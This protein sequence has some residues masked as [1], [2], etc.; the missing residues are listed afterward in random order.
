MNGRLTKSFRRL[1]QLEASV[2]LGI[3]FVKQLGPDD[4]LLVHQE[5]ARVGYAFS[6][7]LGFAIP[8]SVG[9]NGV[10]AFI[11]QQRECNVVF[12]LRSLKHRERVVA[13]TDDLEAGGFNVFEVG[14]QLN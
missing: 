13:D 11:G 6:A 2:P 7:S 1:N 5:G 10:T 14:L 3:A 8:N 9:V 12:G 4:T